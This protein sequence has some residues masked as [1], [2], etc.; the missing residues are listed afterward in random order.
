MKPGEFMG[1][2]AT[3]GMLWTVAILMVI[4]IVMVFLSLTL[5][6]KANRWANIIV[7]II[8]IGLNLGTMAGFPSW[9][10][11]VLSVGIGFNVLTIW[12]AWKWTD[13]ET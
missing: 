11:F 13:P 3:Q 4:P 2:E 5:K 6:Y 1:V 10:K 12:Y 9:Y 7:A 8:F